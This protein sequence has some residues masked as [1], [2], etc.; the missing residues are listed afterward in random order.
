MR[1]SPPSKRAAGTSKIRTGE[2][3]DLVLLAKSGI[4]GQQIPVMQT[5]D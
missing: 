3:T 4:I 1:S 5:E 2:M